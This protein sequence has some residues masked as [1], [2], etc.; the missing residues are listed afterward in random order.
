MDYVPEVPAVVAKIEQ[1]KSS[2]IQCMVDDSILESEKKFKE[3]YPNLSYSSF[4][5]SALSGYFLITLENGS[6]AYTDCSFRY[7]FIG[8]IFDSVTGDA[9]DNQL[10][11][12]I[13]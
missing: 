11:G 10:S 1:I 3:H 12:K 7:L 5:N 9:V 4:K 2:A 13:N 8:I 6:F